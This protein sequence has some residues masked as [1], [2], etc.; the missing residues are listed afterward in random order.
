MVFL[1]G[2]ATCD[3]IERHQSL[4]SPIRV[5]LLKIHAVLFKN[6]ALNVAST[7]ILKKIDILPSDDQQQLRHSSYWKQFRF[8]EVSNGCS[9]HQSCAEGR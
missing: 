6:P 3:R 4:D 8:C 7:G 2:R 1:P 9:L 5:V